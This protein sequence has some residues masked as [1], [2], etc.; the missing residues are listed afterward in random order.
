[1]NNIFAEEFA[2]QDAERRAK[3]AGAEGM[4]LQVLS[5]GVLDRMAIVVAAAR[6]LSETPLSGPRLANLRNALAQLDEVGRCPD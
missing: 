5:S 3:I 6:S 2:R 1:M 4:V